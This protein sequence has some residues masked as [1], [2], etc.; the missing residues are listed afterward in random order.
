MIDDLEDFKAYLK[1][2]CRYDYDRINQPDIKEDALYAIR[3][4]HDSPFLVWK[5]ISARA[6]WIITYYNGALPREVLSGQLSP[7]DFCN[8]ATELVFQN[9]I[10]QNNEIVALRMQY[11]ENLPN[12]VYSIQPEQA[13]AEYEKK[14]RRSG[15]NEENTRRAVMRQEQGFIYCAKLESVGIT[16]EQ[17]APAIRQAETINIIE[18]LAILTEQLKNARTE[19]E[20]KQISKQIKIFIS[21]NAEFLY[22]NSDEIKRINATLKN[23]QNGNGDDDPP[24]GGGGNDDD[25]PPGGGGGGGNGDDDPPGGGGGGGIGT[26][27]DMRRFGSNEYIAPSELHPESFIAKELP[28]S[29]QPACK[30]A[31]AESKEDLGI[32]G[33]L[34]RKID[35]TVDTQLKIADN[36]A[37]VKKE[38]CAYTVTEKGEAE[39]KL[40]R[41]EDQIHLPKDLSR[42][43]I[44][45]LRSRSRSNPEWQQQMQH[46]ATEI[47]AARCDSHSIDDFAE[48]LYQSIG[49]DTP[50]PKQQQTHNSALP[51]RWCG[52]SY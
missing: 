19:E 49:M 32:Y 41:L 36:A 43:N 12:M 17:A 20:K 11:A 18:Q 39:D 52:K 3:S 26:L 6:P 38:R 28:S 9:L 4:R 13:L 5:Y 46:I 29:D 34:T 2:N 27:S 1:G 21:E 8:L 24:S 14:L 40:L 33:Y 7:Q 25:D 35:E 47:E 31:I 16:E 51:I 15:Y 44:E 42:W 48:A 22:N 30:R 50:A 45:Y 23:I 10:Y 37:T